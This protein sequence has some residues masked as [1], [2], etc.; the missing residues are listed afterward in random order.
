MACFFIDSSSS[1]STLGSS[2]GLFVGIFMYKSISELLHLGES[3]F[4][5]SFGFECFQ[6]S[7]NISGELCISSSCI[8]SLR[9]VQISG[10]T[11]HRS[12]QT[13][14]SSFTLLWLGGGILAFH[15]SQHVERYSSSASYCKDLVRDG[16]GQVPGVFYHCI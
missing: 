4:S 3:A 2:R 7:L 9:S 1:V 6:P 16:S 13:S 14:N 15:S 5:G 8:I 10:R 11:S 12:I